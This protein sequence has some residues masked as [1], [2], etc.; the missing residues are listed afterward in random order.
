MLNKCFILLLF[1]I[2]FQCKYE[3]S[4]NDKTSQYFTNIENGVQ[5]GNVRTLTIQSLGKKHKIWTKTIGNNPKT[6]VLLLQGGPGCTHEYFE[7]FEN[8]LPSEGIE[9]IYYDQLGTGNSD[10]PDDTAYWDLSRYV[11]ELE[12]VRTQLNLNESNFYLLGHS[13]GGILAM[14]YAVHHGKNLKALIISNMMASCPL[15]DDYAKNVLSKKINPVFLDSI[16]TIEKNNDF[17]NPA[18]MRILMPNFYNQFICRIPIDQWPEPMTRSFNN[19][20]H[21]LY[22]TMQGPSEFGIAGRLEKWDRSLELKNFNMPVLVIGAN[23]DTMDPAYMKWMSEQIKNSEFV[24]CSNGSHMCMYD[25]QE[26]YFKS[27]IAFIEKTEM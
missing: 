22:V 6:R 17:D 1:T 9:F 3:G 5:D 21:S 10:N 27:L 26:V 19:I 4:R 15:Y 18:Y 16:K 23:H 7:C 13:W 25:D 2:F 20:N 11:D 24:L 14:E 12:Q 8:F